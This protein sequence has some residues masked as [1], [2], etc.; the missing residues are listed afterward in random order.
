MW[1]RV[2]EE[3]VNPDGRVERAGQLYE[4]AVFGGD[5]GA[6]ATAE[7]ELDA[8]QAD[9]SLARGRIVHGRFLEER[10]EEPREL[11]LFERAATLYGELGDVRGEGEAL[12]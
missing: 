4:R 11:T 10:R 5:V 7:R 8:G 2:L 12:F 1:P 9:L 6:L 3:T